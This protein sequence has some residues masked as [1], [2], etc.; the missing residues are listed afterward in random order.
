[1]PNFTY[2]AINKQ[3][4]QVKGTIESESVEVASN[5][6]KEQGMIPTKIED[7]LK[8]SGQESTPIATLSQKKG[9]TMRVTTA[10]LLLFTKQ[11]KAMLQNGV[12]ILKIL[13]VMEKNYI[14]KKFKKICAQMAREIREGARLYE[15]MRK[16][17][18][19]FN[20]LFCSMVEYGENEENDDDLFGAFEILIV[21]IENEYKVKSNIKIAF[22][23]PAF[24]SIALISTFFV[25]L[26]IFKSQNLA[27]SFSTGGLC[28]VT[29]I[30]LLL[31][32]IF[33]FRTNNGRFQNI[34]I[35]N[36]NI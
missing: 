7:S 5:L 13:D 29:I 26:T 9:N 36:L 22:Q 34:T 19:V 35:M 21:I 28:L 4:E 30:G 27:L 10:D 2:H 8:I 14:N 17:P 24:V 12:P 6:L 16:Y 18:K 33:Y 25:L 1:M 15:A 31:F 23:Y 32:L 20:E 11:F 3:G